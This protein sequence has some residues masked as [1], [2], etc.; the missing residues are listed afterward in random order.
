MQPSLPKLAIIGAGLAG[1]TLASALSAHYAITVFEKSRGV[2]GRMT[3]RR[4]GGFEFDHGAQH[5]AARSAQFAEQLGVWR[6]QGL[7]DS[8][9]VGDASTGISAPALVATPRMNSLCKAQLPDSA[10]L[11]LN[12]RV[13]VLRRDNSHW[14]LVDDN[15]TEYPG[16]SWVVCTAP[17]P[18]TAQLLPPQF[19]DFDVLQT[20]Y[21]QGC[22]AL[23]LGFDSAIDLPAGGMR[24]QGSAVGWIAKNSS[25][26][27]RPDAATLLI[28]S[29]NDWAEQHID[30]DE[31]WVMTQLRE[32]AQQLL[33]RELPEPGYQ[34]L[35]RWRYAATSQPANRDYLI[36]HS[37]QLAAC[38]DWCIGS[39]VEAAYL[40]ATALSAALQGG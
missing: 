25:K 16:F 18:Q 29:N 24:Y 12:T 2:G 22:F 19:I 20:V 14:T 35:H 6:E 1:T 32:A 8:W 30:A 17:A 5:F 27:G 31:S 7:V 36:D 33:D 28:Q 10:S 23:M 39:R 3:T 4:A 38:G 21:M 34:A 11:Q 15:E 13:S 9:P 37:L 26:S 40:S